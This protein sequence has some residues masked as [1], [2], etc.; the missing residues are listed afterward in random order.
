[1]G[2]VDGRILSAFHDGTDSVFRRGRNPG[3]AYVAER[4]V[5]TS[6]PRGSDQFGNL[7]TR[8]NLER[9]DYARGQPQRSG[10][11]LGFRPANDRER[12]A[13]LHSLAGANWLARRGPIP[14]RCLDVG[15]RK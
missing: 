11:L 2:T 8:A 7:P 5:T 10:P 4:T 13:R 12:G 9:N 1:M 6:S 3:R 15:R 14:D